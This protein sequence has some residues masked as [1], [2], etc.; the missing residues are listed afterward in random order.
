[1]KI[2]TDPVEIRGRFVDTLQ[3]SNKQIKND[4]ASQIAD[5][6]A[7]F[8]RRKVEDIAEEIKN[9]KIKREG[10]LDVSPTNAQSLMPANDFKADEFVALD[11][12]LGLQIRNL[13]IEL[14]LG[15]KR[16]EELFEA[17]EQTEE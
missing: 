16:Y 9:L 17:N 4:R 8:Y 12:Q 13:E 11:I 10:L 1:M 2:N 15:I 3:R 6:A 14:E 7:R 5:S